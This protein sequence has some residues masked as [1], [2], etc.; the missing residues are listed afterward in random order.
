MCQRRHAS[1]RVSKLLVLFGKKR[2]ER[3]LDVRPQCFARGLE[4]EK[5]DEGL[6]GDGV[7]NAG[8]MALP[9]SWMERVFLILTRELMERSVEKNVLVGVEA[10]EETRSKGL[11]LVPTTVIVPWLICVPLV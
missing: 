4:V 2:E 7:D 3:G 5:E 1:H 6:C 11:L 9:E 8:R 10:L